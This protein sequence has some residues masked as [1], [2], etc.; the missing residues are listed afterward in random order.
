M[1]QFGEGQPRKRP[2]MCIFRLETM[3]FTI[4]YLSVVTRAAVERPL[5]DVGEHLVVHFRRD[6]AH[7]SLPKSGGAWPL[8]LGRTTLGPFFDRELEIPFA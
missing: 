4:A 3:P 5:I 1:C 7:W 6:E 2:G 8:A